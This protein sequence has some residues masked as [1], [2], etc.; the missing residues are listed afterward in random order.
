MITPTFPMETTKY[1]KIPISSIL[2]DEKSKYYLN[3][4]MVNRIMTEKN[5]G[6]KIVDINKP[7]NTILTGYGNSGGYSSL[8]KYS[9]TKNRKL[10]ILELKRIQSFP[11]DY[12]IEG[13][14]NE[15]IKQIGNAV[16]CNLA[17]HMGRHLVKILEK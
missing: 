1:N 13:S 14:N 17:Y 6:V 7:C 5:Y 9:D 16:P 11:D 10:T 15:I 8:I 2:L 12:I 3:E 4:N